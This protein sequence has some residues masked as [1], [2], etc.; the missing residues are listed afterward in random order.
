MKSRFDPSPAFVI[1]TGA[2]IW[3]AL[4]VFNA[5]GGGLATANVVEASAIPMM[6]DAEFRGSFI[7]RNS[8]GRATGLAD[9]GAKGTQVIGFSKPNHFIIG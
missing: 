9:G 7:I 4:I 1:P 5:S 8:G 3:L 6:R 2:V